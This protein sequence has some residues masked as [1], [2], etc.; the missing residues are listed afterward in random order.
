MPTAVEEKE[1]AKQEHLEKREYWWW[2]E[3]ARTSRI[4]YLRKACWPKATKGAVYQPG[5][6][7]DTLMLQVFTDVFQRPLAAT[8]PFILTRARAYAEFLEKVP[9]FIID[10]SR[11]VGYLGSAPHMIEW[12]PIMSYS[13]NE[14]TFNDRTGLIDDPR[15]M[16]REEV[17][18]AIDWWKPRT[19]ETKCERY[20]TRREK[21]NAA[22]AITHTGNA[23]NSV[24]ENPTPQYDWILKGYNAIIKQI[25]ENLALA[26]Q[27]LHEDVPNAPEQLPWMD[28]MDNWQAMKITLEAGIKWAKR[29]S[30]LARIIAEN[31][32]TDP[33]R[34]EELLRIAQT[35]AKIPAEPPEHLWEAI[36]FDM[37]FHHLRQYEMPY[38]AWPARP[39]YWYYPYYKK[40]VTDEKNIV[41]EDALDYVCEWLIRA[42]ETTRSLG[43]N[44]RELM[45]GSSG[46]WV[47]TIGGV[48]PEDGSDAC[49]DLTDAILE[50]ARLVRVADPTYGFRYHPKAR[51]Q[52]L[53]Q[54]FEC[55]RHGLG[56]P[57]M[58]NDPVLITN[59][60]NWSKHPIEEARTWVHQAC[61][62]PCPTTKYGAQPIRYANAMTL[63]SK[64]ME[65]ALNNGWDPVSKMQAGPKTGDASKFTAF[66]ELYQAT[67]AQMKYTMWETA[68]VRHICRKVEMNEFGKPFCSATFERCVETGE[69]SGKAKE[70]GNA[71]FSYFCWMDMQD[72]LAA[73]KKLVFEE[74][75]YTMTE[76][77]EALKTSWEGREE[78]R[79]DFV[80]APKWGNDD[81]YVDE[82][83]VRWHRDFID[84]A[85]RPAVEWSGTPWSIL[86]QNI[87]GYVVGGTRIGALP[88]GRRLG[89]T[90]YDG[91]CSPGAGLDK[92]GPTA[93]LRSVSKLDHTTM[94]R[95]SLLNQRLNPSQ[96]VGDKGFE[97]WLNYIKTWADL[98][99]NHVQFNMIDN[100]TLYAA[101]KEPEKYNELVVRV[102]GYSAHFVELNK[103]TQDTIIARTVQTL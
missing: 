10:H 40:D 79:M 52:T 102:A 2:A 77:I 67:L 43:R 24:N 26:H 51:V 63:C 45:Q 93:V 74:K 7:W 70:R 103:K 25:N 71:W 60:V 42:Y 96:L 99:I 78:M 75:K 66:E 12:T 97:L 86:P 68:R 61:M 57:S 82:L 6:K 62:S 8:E 92:K 55:I 94:F 1:K 3:R 4:D 33:Q 83:V 85:C 101:Q 15:N 32:E 14:D 11:I 89:D 76:L 19:F 17:K 23:H 48:K 90:M 100:E 38:T 46:P 56:Y 31:F 95:A 47:W 98:G 16:S 41:Q 44:Q 73:A 50:A 36:Q 35:C 28:K 22:L 80:R 39:D 87:S 34:K 91:G 49:N 53:R 58:R 54:V 81:D 30:R 69:N 21:M 13:L 5:I 29:Y 37:L 72:G 88:N 65:L 18:K 64:A 20:M 59:I 9:V 84:Q 27:K